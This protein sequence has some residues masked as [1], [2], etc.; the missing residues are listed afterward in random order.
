MPAPKPATDPRQ[1]LVDRLEPIVVAAGFDL[2]ALSVQTVGRRSV[3][4]LVVD[5]DNGVDLD[6]VAVL[7]RAISEILDVEPAT[8]AFG[9]SYVL[10]VSSP[11]VDRPLT[12]E[13]HW[14]RAQGRLV[15]VSVQGRPLTGRIQASSTDGVTLAVGATEQ[16]V[17]W[18]A[19]GP[20]RVQVEFNRGSGAGGHPADDEVADDELADDEVADDEPMEKG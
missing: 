11:G 6:E 16:L 10:E 3:V 19:L 18:A 15:T 7:S 20:G 4:R 13:R 2:E 9:D 1:R 5:A 14:R 17:E 8:D 12:L